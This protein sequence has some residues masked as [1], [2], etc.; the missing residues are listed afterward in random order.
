MTSSSCSE[1]SSDG[2]PIVTRV[3]RRRAGLLVGVVLA[4]VCVAA[5]RPAGA[6][7]LLLRS[8]PANGST[9]A[10]PPDLVRLWFSEEISAEVSTARLVDRTGTTVGGT[11]LHA[12]AETLE[13]RVPHL[14]RG[15]Y[16][17]LWRV[18]AEDDGHTSSG[19]MV[20]SVGASN[21]TLAV[22]T[23]N[24][25]SSGTTFDAVRR[26]VG[27][28]LL[29]GV[30]GGLA[31]ALFVLGR[32][33]DE[34]LVA[35]TRRRLLIVVVAC[36]GLGAPLD[37]VD[38]VAQA[39]RLAPPG[40]SWPATLGDLLTSSRW[41]HL[42]LAHQAALLAVVV[43]VAGLRSSG[44]R[45]Y[46]AVAVGL[47]VTLAGIEALGS[48]AATVG[49]PRTAAIVSDTV[50]VLAACLWLGALPALLVLLAP[51]RR[52]ERLR[53]TRAP[54]TALLA[55][56]VLAT[57]TT[58]LYNAGRQVD[59]VGELT[60]TAYGRALLIKSGLLVTM[61]LLGLASAR[62]WHAGRSPVRHVVAAEAVLGAG[63]LVAVAVLADTPPARGGTAGAPGRSDSTTVADLL[64]TV[65][66][67]PNQ[68]GANGVTVLI[69]SSRRPP[70]A[71][72]SAVTLD[73]GGRTIGLTPVGTG[74]YFGTVDFAGPG[75]ASL[76]AALQRA[77]QTLTVTVPWP[78]GRPGHAARLAPFVNSL[79]VLLLAGGTLA[80]W[81][82]LRRRPARDGPQPAE[83]NAHADDAF[84]TPG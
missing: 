47:A 65:S 70:P 67:A 16:G 33:R 60:S 69:A 73:V 75:T 59:T 11:S 25:D 51:D 35:A 81:Y 39:H 83:I 21:G 1:G 28:G 38:A 2:V 3:G 80:G 77:G 42:W 23:G 48:H 17:V 58:G 13:L 6:H 54:F 57:I 50:H 15:T 71:P 40:R 29:S 31:V 63:L 64:V 52:G 7:A 32:V 36:A 37:A 68:P 4:L 72:V 46:P 74:R 62:R 53:A 84:M 82:V 19:T 27:L 26:W 12:E 78:V 76:H 30:I 79:A 44:R 61:L 43:V 10:A 20:F 24:G 18:L 14:D 45:A 9:V 56:S 55:G 49:P 66:A 34:Q 5:P 41:G 8:Q 22:T